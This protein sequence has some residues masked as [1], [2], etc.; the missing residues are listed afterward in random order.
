M[1]NFIKQCCFNI[2]NVGQMCAQLGRFIAF[3]PTV[4]HKETQVVC[5]EL[6][7]TFYC[8]NDLWYTLGLILKLTPTMT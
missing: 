7:Y 3:T 2:S 5:L 4:T 8:V 1:T 6:K